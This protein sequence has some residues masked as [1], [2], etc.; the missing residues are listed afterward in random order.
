MFHCAQQVIKDYYLLKH[1]LLPGIISVLHTNGSDLKFHPHIHMIVSAGGLTQDGELEEFTS[2][3]LCPQRVLAN[4]FKN[5]FISRLSEK[6]EDQRF[7]SR[8]IH[9]LGK[10][11]QRLNCIQSKAKLLKKL[12][13][14]SSQQWIAHIDKP[15]D[16]VEK[17]IAY[18]GRYTKKSCISERRILSIDNG[19]IKISFKDYKNS[20]RGEKPIDGYLTL[21]STEFLDRLFEHL[22]EKGFNVVRYYGLY[23][24]SYIDQIPEDK[25]IKELRIPAYDYSTL[26]DFDDAVRLFHKYRK[27]ILENTGKDPLYCYHCNQVMKLMEI[28]IEKDGQLQIVDLYNSD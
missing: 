25:K 5:L 4:S 20:K 21:S 17:I 18:V 2:D 7:T 19:K 14:A 15:L 24:S 27:T 16:G 26:E 12:R 1:G 13:G 8:L 23:S 10:T 6:F 28:H 3:Y 11:Y 22:P 9:G